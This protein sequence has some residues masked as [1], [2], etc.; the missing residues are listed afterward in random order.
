M[1]WNA[2]YHQLDP[3]KLDKPM[4]KASPHFSPECRLGAPTSSPHFTGDQSG[5]ESL[6][7]GRKRKLGD[8][9]SSSS[10]SPPVI[11][12]GQAPPPVAAGK[13][14]L[15]PFPP[16]KGPSESRLAAAAGITVEELW[17]RCDRHNLL[18]S[19]PGGRPAYGSGRKSTLRLPR[20]AHK[21]GGDQFP[22]KEGKEAASV[23][24]SGCSEPLCGTPNLPK[25]APGH[26]LRPRLER[27]GTVV[28]LGLN[29]ARAF[30]ITN[31]KLFQR[32]TLVLESTGALGSVGVTVEE[33]SQGGRYSIS[34]VI[35]PHPS[36]VSHW[37]NDKRNR[38][39]ASDS[40]KNIIGAAAESFP[41]L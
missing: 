7:R 26:V 35:F 18:P 16:F 13:G 23:L 8:L 27:Y 14:P 29:V 39:R 1:N 2:Q 36:G 38:Q 28:L 34:A 21:S 9:N 4:A 22:L 17:G 5:T 25:A 40:L 6:P 10:V 11:F 20:R 24:L 19:F 37:W 3:I 12:I 15:D 31:P 33:G 32:T 30:G 41:L